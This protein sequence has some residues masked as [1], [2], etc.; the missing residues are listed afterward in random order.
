MGVRVGTICYATDQGLGRLVKDFYDNGVIHEVAIFKHGSRV[1]HWEWYP[2]GTTRVTT[3][4]IRGEVEG[5]LGKIDVLL[6][7]ETPWDWSL[8]FHCRA[9]SVKTVIVPMYECMPRKIEP[10]NLPDRWICPSLL[11]YQYYTGP[12]GCGIEAEYVPVP[13]RVPW[14]A[15]SKAFTF[16]HNAGNFGL[17]G[18]NGTTELIHAVRHLKNPVELTIRGQDGKEMAKVMHEYRYDPGVGARVNFEAGTMPYDNLFRHYDV[19]VAPEKFN[20]LSLPLQEARAAGMLVL[21]TDRFP[22]NKFLE[23]PPEALIGPKSVSRACVGQSFL[24]FDE[25]EVSPISIA[26]TIDRWYGESI[27]D[28]GRSKTGKAWSQRRGLGG[29]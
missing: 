10:E 22:A 19:Y 18:R 7:F 28:E 11:D 14:D 23:L 16:L 13:V 29:S 27:L 12:Q 5:F 17:R 2:E 6:Q 20:G 15:R 3:R 1:N 9:K 24:E 25:C 4:P 26:R 21:T 8:I